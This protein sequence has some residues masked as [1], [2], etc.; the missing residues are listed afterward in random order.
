MV[1]STFGSRR[2]SIELENI[3]LDDESHMYDGADELFAEMDTSGR[4]LLDSE[5]LREFLR[6]FDY[7]ENEV[8]FLL[9]PFFCLDPFLAFSIPVS[10]LLRHR[11]LSGARIV[12]LIFLTCSLLC[13]S[14]H[15]STPSPFHLILHFVFLLPFS[16]SHASHA[17]THCFRFSI[18]SD[19]WTRIK[20]DS[21]ICTNFAVGM[22]ILSEA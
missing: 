4:G 10:F 8:I 11:F 13:Q 7:F 5:M 22:R 12:Y 20:M 6:E 18:F 2:A 14:T 9:F 15:P 19:K 3:D 21:G 1:S 16:C 17:C